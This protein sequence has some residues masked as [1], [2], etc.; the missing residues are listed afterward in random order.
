[1][2]GTILVICGVGA[3]IKSLGEMNDTVVKRGR[4]IFGTRYKTT[5]GKCFRCNGTG[6]VYGQVCRKCG[7]SGYYS[8]RTWYR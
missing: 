5:K 2:L 1:M 6:V 4:D 8:H 7:G 3:A